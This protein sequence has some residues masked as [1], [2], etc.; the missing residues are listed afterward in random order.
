VGWRGDTSG[1]R[2]DVD[3]AELLDVGQKHDTETVLAGDALAFGNR[4][5]ESAA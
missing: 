1:G 3:H 4:R 2:A 5:H